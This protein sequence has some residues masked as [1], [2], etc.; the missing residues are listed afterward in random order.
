MNIK[1][2]K[3]RGMDRTLSIF[4]DGYEFIQKRV[5]NHHLDVFETRVLGKKT[6][7]LSGEEGA[8]LFYDRERMKRSGAMPSH[9]L[10]SLFGEGGVQGLD[11]AVHEH[12]KL[13]FMNLMTPSRLHD[14]HTIT[15]KLWKHTAD[16]WVSKRK[17]VLFD[18]TLLLLTRAG[19]EWAG[20]PLSDKEAPKRAKELNLL[21]EGA[22]KVG[23]KYLSSVS[24]RK[25]LEEWLMKM[26]E[27]VRAGNQLAAE[28]RALHEIATH[29]DI[30]GPPLQAK[31]AAVELLN[32]IRPLVAVSRYI[33]FGA[34]AMQEH[35]ESKIKIS[36]NEGYLENFIQEVRRFYPFF[37]FLAA[38]AKND[39]TWQGYSFKEG[40]LVMLDLYGTNHDPRLWES[41]DKFMPD[42]FINYVGSQYDLIPQGGG[43]HYKNHRCP[44]EWPT[45]EVMNASFKFLASGI[46]YS[47]PKQDISYS[48]REIPSLPKSGFVMKN[49]RINKSPVK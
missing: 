10:K 17:I 23:P 20:I 16:N 46:S 6:A 21:I 37:P 30:N 11:G 27:N 13:L 47:F 38:R 32:I 44:G 8:R 28:G 2:P 36:E 4:K 19:C 41:P 5:Q 49:I 42:R 29:H 9:I 1:I 39:F 24:A 43:D 22:S 7:L 3:D 26:I 33:V 14:L 34:C 12:R 45:I 18:E 31:T 40:Q 15:T 48:L 35:P 25:H